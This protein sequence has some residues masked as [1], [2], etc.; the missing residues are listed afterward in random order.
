RT[1]CGIVSSTTAAAPAWASPLL[2]REDALARRQDI[3]GIVALLE[4]DQFGPGVPVLLNPIL[5]GELN[6]SDRIARR[7]HRSRLVE[8]RAV[9]GQHRRQERRVG[10]R[11]R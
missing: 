10:A 4:I 6:A 11:E 2:L 5:V 7:A 3:S 1:T 9:P 8:E